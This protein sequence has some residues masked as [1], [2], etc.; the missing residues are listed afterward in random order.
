MRFIAVLFILTI[1]I[2]PARAEQYGLAMV[3]TPTYTAGDTHLSYA[4]PDAPKK[5]AQEGGILK[6]AAIGTFDTVNPYTIKG[7]AAGGLTLI[8]DRLMRRVWDEPFTMYPLIAKSYDMPE[9][10]SQISFTLDER[11]RFHDSTSITVDDVEFSFKTLRDFGRPNMRRV[12][13]LVSSIQKTDD[14][15]TFIFGAG[16][17]A[18]TPLILAM[19]PV[20]SETYWTENEFDTTTLSPDILTN[21]P[22]RIQSIDPGRQIVYERVP[23]YW[24]KDLLVNRGHHNFERIIYDYYRDNGVAFEAF[25]AGEY[26]L[27]VEF[28]AGKWARDYDFPAV[29]DGKIIAETIPH[30]RP[31][32]LR[33][34]I[35]NTRRTPFDDRR[36]REA[37]N[38]LFDF[39]WINQNLF[40]GQYKRINSY[41]P[42]SELA[43]RG[44]PD[45]TQTCVLS[46]FGDDL[47]E[48]VLGKSYIPPTNDTP[49][50]R[51]ANMRKA[52]QL[53]KEAGWVVQDG[54]RVKNGSPFTFEMLLGAPAHEKIA[55]HFKQSLAKMGIEMTIRVLDTAAFQD[56]LKDYNFDMTTHHWNNSL[57]P[58]AEQLLYW[59][60]KAKD[61]Q[62]RWNYAG[63]CHPAIDKISAT[64]AKAKTRKNLV[65]YARSLDRILTHG[66]YIIPLYYAGADYYARK[67][68]IHRPAVT[69]LYGVVTETWWMEEN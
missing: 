40:F 68:T 8:Y 57:S 30:S 10:R 41:Y 66:Q 17:D 61:E 49:Q 44:M 43:A 22:Y 21:G 62:A 45:D 64:L 55:L 67:S 26:D 51:R 58:G 63:I 65:A 24:A 31:E 14:T 25:K 11:A 46:S 20:L 13:R 50:N 52:D 18:E 28:D 5:T 6:H 54:K 47:P 38:L 34:M 60:C 36:V 69:P 35:F 33:A 37:L 42:N 15:I 4:N 7:K 29:K 1:I 48:S 9:D 59:G 19:M 2:F 27:H 3:G 32:R 23:D 39:E 16:A 12:Y 56:R 53:L